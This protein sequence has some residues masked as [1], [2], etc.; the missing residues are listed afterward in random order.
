MEIEYLLWVE[1]PLGQSF[2]AAPDSS[3]PDQIQMS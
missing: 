2:Q 1:D 3:H